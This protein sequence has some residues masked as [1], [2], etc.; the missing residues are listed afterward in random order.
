M[1]HKTVATF[2]AEYKDAVA[3]THRFYR[4][5]GRATYLHS[6]GRVG[7]WHKV[8]NGIATDK[9]FNSGVPSGPIDPAETTMPAE[10]RIVTPAGEAVLNLNDADRGGFWYDS[11]EH[12]RIWV[13][14][15]TFESK[16]N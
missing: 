14:T 15:F 2:S 5:T 10:L 4:E 8:V 3:K 9:N 13:E 11:P 16:E 1:N 6:E 7:Y 12:G